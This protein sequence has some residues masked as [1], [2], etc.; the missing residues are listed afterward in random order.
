MEELEPLAANAWAI[1]FTLYGPTVSALDAVMESVWGS[2]CC[3]QFIHQ[4]LDVPQRT[5]TAN[6]GGRE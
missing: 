6:R 5:A 1:P 2:L 4:V 3:R